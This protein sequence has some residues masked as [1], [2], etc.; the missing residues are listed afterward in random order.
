MNPRTDRR[1]MWLVIGL[2]SF[3]VV[4]WTV[5]SVWTLARCQQVGGTPVPSSYPHPWQ[6]H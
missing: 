4:A 5:V 2:L 3:A 6:C 1:L